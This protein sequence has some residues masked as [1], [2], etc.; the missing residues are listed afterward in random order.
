MRSFSLVRVVYGLLFLVAYL[1]GLSSLCHAEPARRVDRELGLAVAKVCA[2]EAGFSSPADCDLIWQ[3]VA[4]HHPDSRRR[5][6]WLRAHSRRVLGTRRCRG[7]CVWSRNLTRSSR[8]PEGWP[9]GARWRP[10]AWAALL[11]QA[12]ALVAG[13]RV[14][15]P[16]DGAPT[17]WGGAM[18]HA[19]ALRRG[20]IPLTCAGTR[21]R[22][23]ARPRIDR[24][25]LIYRVRVVRGGHAHPDHR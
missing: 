22:G 18:D 4:T 9:E 25:Q 24:T 1:V 14:E 15:A 7:N 8:K 19:G 21:N 17:T 2:N 16:C 3:V 20:L 23:Y 6:A 10:A 5:L 13:D 12:D 11:V